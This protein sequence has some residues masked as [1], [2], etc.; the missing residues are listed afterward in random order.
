MNKT[1]AEPFR[2]ALLE[3]RERVAHAVE[4]LHEENAGSLEDETG[5]PAAGADDHLGDVAT[6]T[7]DRE[8]NETL[9]ESA[10][11]ILEAID[12]A[13]KR[14]EE[15]TYGNC[16]NCG[17]AISSERLEAIPWTTWCIDCKRKLERG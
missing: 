10:E 6:E 5:E 2:A 12:V 16:E 17:Q 11:G 13:L 15:G 8:L 3:E 1:E 14:I 4:Y 9:G 7:F